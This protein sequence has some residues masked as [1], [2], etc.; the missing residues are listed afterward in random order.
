MDILSTKLVTGEEIIA[1]MEMVEDA[2]GEPVK[3]LADKPRTFQVVGVTK[4]NELQTQ[5]LPFIIN[6]PDGECYIY[7]SA[8]LIQP[9]P[10]SVSVGRHYQ[11]QTTGLD[12]STSVG[13]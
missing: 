6:D 10:V 7:Q 8:M 4:N 3:W 12:L 5:M 2:K 9:Q 11:E 13:G 1:K